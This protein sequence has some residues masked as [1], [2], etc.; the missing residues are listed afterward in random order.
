MSTLDWPTQAYDLDLCVRNFV[1]GHYTDIS[2]GDSLIDKHSPRDG[3]LLYQLGSG[4]A[5]DVNAAVANAQDAFDDGRWRA[6]PMA[7]R[8]AVL[9][10]LAELVEANS[11]E[12]ALFESLDVGKPISHALQGDIPTVAHH[13]RS[14]AEL[15]DKLLAPSGVD[16]SNFSFQLRK[17]I[18]VVG[19]IVGWNF[20]LSLAATKVGPA[21]VMG[22][23]LVLKPSEFTSLSA[24]RLAELAIEAGVPSGVFNVVHGEGKTVGAALA[25]HTDVGLL[26]FTGSS[27]TGKQLM[28]AAGQSNMKRV[29]LECGGKSPYLI[30]DDCPDDLDFLAADIVETSFA[31]QGALCSSSTR[32]LIHESLIEKLLPKIVAETEKLTP[33]DPLNPETSFG[34]IINEAHL[35]KVMAYI[36]SGKQEGATLVTGGNR[37]DVSMCDESNS[38]NSSNNK[39]YYIRPAIFTDVDPNQKIAQEEIFGPV[40]SIFTFKDEAEAIQMANN[41]CYG[42]AAYA[43][44]TNLSRAH[45]IT[46]SLNAGVIMIVGTSTPSAGGVALSVEPHRESGMGT[47]FGLEGL[48]AYTLSSAVHM[49]T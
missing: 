16:G 28:I 36:E 49:L 46:Q 29:M 4:T 25:Q 18:G 7:Q 26:T 11:E 1:D 2:T 43:A 3:R 33:Q 24:A 23:S 10:K 39:G 41:S 45:R 27:A 30:F 40:L 21:L 48:V 47:E 32:L 34:A 38:A 19:A 13:L 22:N 35:N 5:E 15:A 14:S 6:L 20:P 12:L 8:Q 31:N 44:T 42:L 37:I 17:P 9:C